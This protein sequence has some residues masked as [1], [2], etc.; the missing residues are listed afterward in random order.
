MGC[1]S[2]LRED[3]A[4]SGPQSLQR[5]DVDAL[6][7]LVGIFVR[8][9]QN[10]YELGGRGC[11]H[12]GYSLVGCILLGHLDEM[13][14]AIIRRPMLEAATINRMR[15]GS[16]VM[17]SKTLP[18]KASSCSRNFRLANRRCR[19]TF[20]RHGRAPKVFG[21][22]LISLSWRMRSESSLREW[23]SSLR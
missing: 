22:W 3:G 14:T 11:V 21:A 8:V 13:R 6:L 9:G 2:T 20:L 4:A 18:L 5:D 17:G 23:T 1:F 15:F 12:G 16:L 7:G 10:R 19:R